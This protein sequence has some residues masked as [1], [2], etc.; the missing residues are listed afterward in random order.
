[1]QVHMSARTLVLF[2]AGCVT[3]IMWRLGRDRRLSSYL[4]KARGG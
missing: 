4:L 3:V 1:M 2:A